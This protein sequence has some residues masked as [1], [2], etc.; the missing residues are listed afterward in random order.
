M[1][2]SKFIL[3]RC[4][5]KLGDFIL[6]ISNKGVNIFEV[7]SLFFSFSFGF[8]SVSDFT[9]TKLI[10]GVNF[11][12]LVGQTT[13]L[14]ASFNGLKIVK[15]FTFE[16]LFL[17]SIFDESLFEFSKINDCFG[18]LTLASLVL[19]I[20]LFVIVID[21]VILCKCFLFSW[22]DAIFESIENNVLLFISF[23][24]SLESCCVLF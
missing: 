1:L 16:I 12:A 18:I 17:L 23:S 9:F 20:P 21:D 13:K 19:N 24:I 10:S 8:V 14:F 22:T 5:F 3:E 6:L 11:K 15:V 2:I 7:A 4:P